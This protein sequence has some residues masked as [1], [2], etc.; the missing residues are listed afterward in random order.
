MTRENAG[1]TDEGAIA[2]LAIAHA[3]WARIVKEVETGDARGGLR[4]TGGLDD[5]P[6]RRAPPLT[7]ADQR[8]KETRHGPLRARGQAH[9]YEPLRADGGEREDVMGDKRC[10]G[11][12]ARGDAGDGGREDGAEGGGGEWRR[13]REGDGGGVS[14]GLRRGGFGEG[15]HGQCHLFV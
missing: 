10:W 3:R 7:R 2:I 9:T 13:R 14:L 12:G 15:R 11:L 6:F 8:G 4:G 5:E 1:L